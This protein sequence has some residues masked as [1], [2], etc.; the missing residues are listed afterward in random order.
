MISKHWEQIKY[1]K[2]LPEKLKTESHK[3]GV[4]NHSINV[5]SSKLETKNP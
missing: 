4:G 2:K 5:P 1:P 3:K